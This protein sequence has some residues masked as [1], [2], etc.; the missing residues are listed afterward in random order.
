LS[1]TYCLALYPIFKIG[2]FVSDYRET[3][4]PREKWDT[5]LKEEFPTEEYGMI[6]KH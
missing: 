2:L 6:E 4:N 1:L 3:N 5:E